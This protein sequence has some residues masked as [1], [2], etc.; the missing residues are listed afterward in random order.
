MIHPYL[1]YRENNDEGELLYFI[2]QKEF[3]NYQCVISDVP[4]RVF[5]EP[6][7]LSGYNLFLIFSGVLRGFM[8][9]S[10]KNVDDEIKSVMFNMAN[11]FFE[12]RILLNEKKYKKWKII[13]TV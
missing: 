9:P 13:A 10:Y 4:K 5:V 11:W 8:L 2:V 3:P 12:N 1:T 7:P 6:M